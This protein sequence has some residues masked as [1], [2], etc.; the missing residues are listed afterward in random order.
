MTDWNALAKR[1]INDEEAFVELYNHFFP[2]VYRNIYI[3]TQN[4]ELADEIIGTVFWKTFNN[5]ERFDERLAS[6]QTWLLR[7][8]QNEIIT[9]YRSQKQKVDNE[10]EMD[11][12]VEFRADERLEP[13]Q[14]LLREEQN[15]QLKAAIQKLN[16]RERQVITLRYYLDMSMEDIAA[17][18]NLTSGNVR[19]ILNRARAKLKKYLEEA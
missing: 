19:V 10:T 5:L 12:E 1:A 11:E 16:E 9:Y 13:E 15:Q 6:F 7:I 14:E 18:L 17:K 2:I 3:K 4:E 8:T